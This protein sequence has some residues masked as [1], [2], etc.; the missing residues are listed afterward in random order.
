MAEESILEVLGEKKALFGSPNPRPQLQLEAHKKVGDTGLLECVLKHMTGKV[1]PG[2]IDRF[3]HRHNADGIDYWLENA[4]QVHIKNQ[5][6]VEDPYW[7]P[8]LG[9]RIGDDPNTK[10]PNLCQGA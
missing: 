5:A 2:C 7:P 9:C 3:R 6:W 10:R 8:L 4:D 1:A